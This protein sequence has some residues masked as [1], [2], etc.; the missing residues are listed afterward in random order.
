[1][2]SFATYK[3]VCYYINGDMMKFGEK[4]KELRVSK[5]M[6]Q[7]ELAEKANVGMS[8]I[9]QYEL[10]YRKPKIENL[11]KIAEALGVSVFEFYSDS[12]KDF[13]IALSSKLEKSELDK[14]ASYLY[15]ELGMEI[16][17]IN[18]NKYMIKF[19]ELDSSIEQFKAPKEP[20]LVS[21]NYLLDLKSKINDCLL[22]EIKSLINSTEALNKILNNPD[23]DFLNSKFDKHLDEES[24]KKIG[25]FLDWYMDKYWK[26][27]YK[28]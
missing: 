3:N 20:I 2:F 21:E 11:E 22:Q 8:T 24:K 15:V 27:I 13:K 12:I 26:G 7:K 1:M 28:D 19:D 10:G 18:K 14:L 9:K 4:I 16:V 5:K 17:P 25:D 6:T 23:F